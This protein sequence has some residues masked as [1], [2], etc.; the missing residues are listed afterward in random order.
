MF[1][2]PFNVYQL[3]APIAF[4]LRSMRS[5]NL[6]LSTGF[7]GAILLNLLGHFKLI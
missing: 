1:V 3:S 2:P 6:R 4:A 5:P 7:H